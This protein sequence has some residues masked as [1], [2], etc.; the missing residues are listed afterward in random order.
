M[1]RNLT[2]AIEAELQEQVLRPHL[3][4]EAEF[5]SGSIYLWT[6][7][8]TIEWNSQTWTGAGNLIGISDIVE[9]SE[10]VSR[11]M[12]V[13]LS[14]VPVDLISLV[15]GDV[16]QGLPGKVYVGLLDEVG[17]V[18]ADPVESF[19]G[20][21]DV[22]EIVDGAETCV[23][24]I[25]YKNRMIDLQTPREFRYTHES[26]KVFFPTDK[27]FEFVTSLQDKEVS[28]GQ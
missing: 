9:T 17:E 5:P 6:G 10:I 3:F 28:W 4:F 22:P 11:G 1:T 2:A 23:I 14:G 12:T 7:A 15:I 21:L 19:A 13:S 8:G 20:R 24:S 16:Q 27:G 26:Q 18:I 25:S